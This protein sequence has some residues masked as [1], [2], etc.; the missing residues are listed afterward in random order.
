M[1][2]PFGFLIKIYRDVDNPSLSL[3]IRNIQFF[4]W[5]FSRLPACSQAAFTDETEER[6]NSRID[7]EWS[8]ECVLLCLFVVGE[9]SICNPAKI[10]AKQ[11]FVYI[12]QFSKTHKARNGF[13]I[14]NGWAILLILK[15]IEFKFEWK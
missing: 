6:K 8:I 9:C 14:L 2:A 7:S 15:H 3:Y 4:I 10:N 5:F 13:I 12:A 1:I 11:M